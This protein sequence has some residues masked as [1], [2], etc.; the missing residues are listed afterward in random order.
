MDALTALGAAPGT[1][2]RQ[3][4]NRVLGYQLGASGVAGALK[5]FFVA[6]SPTAEAPEAPFVL[7]AFTRGRFIRY[8]WTPGSALTSTFPLGRLVGV[9]DL[10]TAE[11]Y[12]VAINID[13]HTQSSTW[14]SET[15]TVAETGGMLS[16]A[17][18]RS[19]GL[20]YRIEVVAARA[21]ALAEFSRALRLSMD[22]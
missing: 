15:Q 18:G 6:S 14:F 7:F 9:E 11:S 17:E 16:R 21:P 20:T 13:W 22:D 8:E 1:P 10:E 3:G 19:E 2:V 5:G 4:L 12:T